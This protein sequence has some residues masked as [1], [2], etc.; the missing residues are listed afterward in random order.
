MGASVTPKGKKQNHKGEKY[1]PWGVGICRCGKRG[2]K[3]ASQ[4]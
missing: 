4:K 3:K 2:E 1:V